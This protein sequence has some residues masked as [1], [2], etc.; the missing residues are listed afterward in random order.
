MQAIRE[1]NDSDVLRSLVAEFVNVFGPG[2]PHEEIQWGGN[3]PPLKSGGS[4]ENDKLP[5]DK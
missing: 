4:Q 1:T 2:W 5:I 3:R